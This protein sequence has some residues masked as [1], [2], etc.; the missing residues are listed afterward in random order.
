MK[1][2]LLGFGLMCGAASLAQAQTMLDGVV[3][4]KYHVATSADHA[5]DANLPIGA[6]TYRIYIDMKAGF[7]LQS[8]YGDA[9]HALS[10]GTTTSF[11]N[12]PNGSGTPNTLNNPAT[13]D[14]YDSWLSLGTD[15]KG[16][17]AVPLTEN[18]AGFVAGTID[19]KSV[20]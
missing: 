4:E 5:I 14:K 12:S 6:T 3:V 15:S 10:F 9:N 1:K 11:Y 13:V 2:L 18:A 16:K 17:L 20:V 7:K 8:V 19:R